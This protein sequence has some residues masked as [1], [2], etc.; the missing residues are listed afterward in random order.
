MKPT[1]PFQASNLKINWAKRHISDLNAV[2]AE[3]AKRNPYRIVV[4]ESPKIGKYALII[5]MREAIPCEFP[6]IIDDSIHNLR[7]S[8]DLLACDLVRLNEGNTANVYFPFASNADGLETAIKKRKID[9]AAPD[10]VEI[11]RS[12]R[13]YTGGNKTLRAIHDLDIID[14]HKLIIPTANL[15]SM[16]DIAIL[17]AG[18]IL[19]VGNKYGPVE[20]GRRMM[21]LPATE[22]IKIGQEFNTTFEIAFGPDAPFQFEPILPTLHQM[23]EL[24]SGIVKTFQTHCLG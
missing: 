14:K 10:V 24:V 5:R 6:A 2:V 9:R 17:G 16:P 8:L 21:T 15:T 7:A 1:E 13:P 22:D 23:T 12:L 19:M 4:E 11:V 18:M 3:F 20:E